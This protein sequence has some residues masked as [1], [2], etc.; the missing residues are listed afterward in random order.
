[1]TK[2]QTRLDDTDAENAIALFREIMRKL[3]DASEMPV[4]LPQPYRHLSFRLAASL[5]LPLEL[6]NNSFRCA[7]SQSGSGRWSMP[8]TR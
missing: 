6:S 4:H 5:P 8:W 2:V 7:T 3:H 1:M